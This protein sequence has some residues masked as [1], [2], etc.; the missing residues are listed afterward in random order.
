MNVGRI[1]NLALALAISGWLLAYYGVMSQLGDPVPG[2]PHSII[3]SDR[4]VSVSILLIGV[5]CLLASL[6]LSGYVFTG[7]RK[8]SLLGGMLIAGPAVVVITNLY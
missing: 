6:W 3:E 5:V 2:T 7:A 8:R 4:H 1:A